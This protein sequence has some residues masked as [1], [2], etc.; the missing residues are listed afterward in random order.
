[1]KLSEPSSVFRIIAIKGSSFPVHHLLGCTEP[2]Y[3]PGLQVAIMHLNFVWTKGEQ[4]EPFSLPSSPQEVTLFS[5]FQKRYNFIHFSL[6]VFVSVTEL[7]ELRFI[8]GFVSM[9]AL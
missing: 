4:F 6:S 3:T 1:M 2:E 8:F 5:S 9:E 7:T